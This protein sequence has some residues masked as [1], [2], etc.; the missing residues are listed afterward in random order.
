MSVC[1]IIH[2]I[3]TAMTLNHIVATLTLDIIVAYTIVA[4]IIPLIALL[5]PSPVMRR[6]DHFWNF[7]ILYRAH[8]SNLVVTESE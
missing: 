7:R 3:V 8:L 6:K 2:E 1:G 4:F 5:T